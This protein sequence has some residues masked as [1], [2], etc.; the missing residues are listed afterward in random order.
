MVNL[1]SGLSSDG[2]VPHDPGF[3]YIPSESCQGCYL[4]VGVQIRIDIILQCCA[5]GQAS[6]SFRLLSK[7]LLVE[8]MLRILQIHIGSNFPFERLKYTTCVF[9]PTTVFIWIFNLSWVFHDIALECILIDWC[10]QNPIPKHGLVYNWSHA[11][12]NIVDKSTHC[13]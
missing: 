10:I 13:F 8:V 4:R 12:K 1:Y 5:C 3:H 9:S 6:L 11:C 7:P 2:R